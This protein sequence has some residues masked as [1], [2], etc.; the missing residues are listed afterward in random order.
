M[1]RR[2][3]GGERPTYSGLGARVEQLLRLTEEQR[4]QILADAR[5]EAADIVD[6][7]RRQAE[8]ILAD[9]RARAGQVDDGGRTE[10]GAG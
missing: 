4:E 7:A 2:D 5:A 1:R 3:K 8:Q 6:E 10:P 9:A